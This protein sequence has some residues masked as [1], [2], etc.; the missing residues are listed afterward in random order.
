MKNVR[1]RKNN[2]KGYTII[3]VKEWDEKE[4]IHKVKQQLTRN[5]TCKRCKRSFRQIPTHTVKD[6]FC[7]ECLTEGLYLLE[8]KDRK[9]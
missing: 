9:G 1:K 7:S 4:T 2:N 3:S 8:Y 6:D 5:C